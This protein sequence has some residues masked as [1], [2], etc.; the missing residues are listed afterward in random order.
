MQGPS[1]SLL[2]NV[3]LCVSPRSIPKPIR[4]KYLGDMSFVCLISA[5]LFRVDD[6][7]GFKTHKII[8]IVEGV[9]VFLFLKDTLKVSN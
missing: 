6:F 4:D 2:K 5:F 7:V 1:D 8:K 3:G 9:C